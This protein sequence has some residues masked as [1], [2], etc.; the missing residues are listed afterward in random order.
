MC[1]AHRVM[2][3]IYRHLCIKGFIELCL[4]VYVQLYFL[5]FA[6]SHSSYFSLCPGLTI[7]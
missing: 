4:H 6:P 5:M 3:W 1:V 2:V 7:Y